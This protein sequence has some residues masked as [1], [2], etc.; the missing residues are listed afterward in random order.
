MTTKFSHEKDLVE[1]LVRRLGLDVDG[2][3]DPNADGLESGAD[4][5][6]R[7]RSQQIGV[8]VTILDTGS[9]WEVPL[10][11]GTGP[12]VMV[13]I[14]YFDVEDRRREKEEARDRAEFLI[15]SGQLSSQQEQNGFFSA[16]NPSQVRL[17]QRQAEIHLA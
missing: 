17:V 5:T 2:Y 7:R 3:E 16:L 6:I 8:Q 13:K 9:K 4:V 14:G 10:V 1:R 15:V 12:F 11:D